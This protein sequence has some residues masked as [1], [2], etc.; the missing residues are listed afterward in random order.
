MLPLLAK[1]AV[2]LVLVGIDGTPVIAVV[3]ISEDKNAFLTFGMTITRA[4]TVIIRP[5]NSRYNNRHAKR[6]NK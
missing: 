6:E 5:A 1:L 4:V 3:N 2:L